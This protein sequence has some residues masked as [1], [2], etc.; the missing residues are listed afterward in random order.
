MEPA[1]THTHTHKEKNQKQNKKKAKK[2][3]KKK[4]ERTKQNQKVTKFRKMIE[5]KNLVVSGT[6][7]KKNDRKKY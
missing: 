5:K 3:K 1:N 7:K 4:K 6:N 2:K